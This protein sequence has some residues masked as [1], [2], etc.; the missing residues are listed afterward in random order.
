MAYLYVW[1]TCTYGLPVRMA[2]LYVWPTCT[3]GLPLHIAY[4][5]TASARQTITYLVHNA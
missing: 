1:P 5:Y 3:Y 4:L 2:Y